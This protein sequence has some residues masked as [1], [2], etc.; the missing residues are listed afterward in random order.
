MA[1][2][3]QCPHDDCGAGFAVDN[4]LHGRQVPCPGCGRLLT[5]ADGS[6]FTSRSQPA[7]VRTSI[8]ASAL[9]ENIRSLHNV[10]SIFR[11]A[12]A[13]GFERLYLAG[14]TGTPPRDEISKTALGAEEV[15]EWEYAQTALDVISAIR[16]SGVQ[17]IALERA[18][19]AVD[20][21]EDIWRP[22][23]CV[24]VGNEVAGVSPEVLAEADVVASL[25]MSGV[26]SSLNVSV[27]FGVAAYHVADVLGGA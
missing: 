1:I 21:R 6:A 20:Y 11:T 17:V 8:L 13:A 27:A 9:L 23:L 4:A 19:G 16:G 12:E 5:A 10:G 22:P 2:E 14:I 18:E 3:I 7:E 15:I 26:K 25:P 24:I